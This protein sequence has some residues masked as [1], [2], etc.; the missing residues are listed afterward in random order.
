MKF[1]KEDEKCYHFSDGGKVVKVAKSGMSD[2]FRK[3]YFAGGLVEEAKKIG[4]KIKG[5]SEQS[6]LGES[7]AYEQVEGINQQQLNQRMDDTLGEIGT[8]ANKIRKP[9]GYANGG[10]VIEDPEL[11]DLAN[12]HGLNPGAKGGLKNAWALENNYGKSNATSVQGARGPMQVM[13]AV[14]DALKRQGHLSPQADINNPSDNKL[15]AVKLMAEA[16]NGKLK[17]VN[18]PQ[19]FAAYYHGGPK[20]IDNY[21]K[22][23]P[24]RKDALGTKTVDYAA[25]AAQFQPQQYKS[26]AQNDVPF[27]QRPEQNFQNSTQF[28]PNQ[29]AIFAD[30]QYPTPQN[31]EDFG[32]LLPVAARERGSDAYAAGQAQYAQQHFGARQGISADTEQAM[33]DS[34]FGVPGQKIGPDYN[35]EQQAPYALAAQENQN[36]I[37]QAQN[38]GGSGVIPAS[39]QAQDFSPLGF[40]GNPFQE[41]YDAKSQALQT[42]AGAQEMQRQAEVDYSGRMAKQQQDMINRQNQLLDESNKQIDAFAKDYMANKVDPNKLF[43]NQST[44]RMF[45]GA[46]GLMLSGIGSALTGQPSQ[47]LM[48]I[49]RAIDRD[50]EAQKLEL[51]KGKT[52]LDLQLQK[53]G[54]ER[55]AIQATRIMLGAQALA[56]MEKAK[57]M[58][59]KP[60]IQAALQMNQANLKLALVQQMAEMKNRMLN[61]RAS[62]GY[63]G[64]LTFGTPEYAM[65]LNNNPDLKASQYV[66]FKAPGQPAKVYFANTPQEAQ[67]FRNLDVAY[68]N[69]KHEVEPLLDPNFV[70]RLKVSEAASLAKQAIDVAKLQFTTFEAAGVGSTRIS[71]LERELSD[72]IIA[73]PTSW[74]PKNLFNTQKR[75]AKFLE[76]IKGARDQRARA[77]FPNYEIDKSPSDYGFKEA[78]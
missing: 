4:K 64:A 67:N 39:G 43:R 5:L 8:T 62:T 24:N 57:A 41:V 1:L 51:G 59:R 45:T 49:D 42:Q 26:S 33:I 46:I 2:N 14:F 69:I 78:K 36:M 48:V 44:G 34:R 28:D 22:I 66:D 25:N 56:E 9:Q 23:N 47:A 15:A 29:P 20:A 19:M 54:N 70:R 60:E 76:Q 3:K 50:I 65:A 38:Q 16:Q 52:I 71:E 37:R 55:D 63:G 53:Y 40:Q 72:D 61:F 6:E 74:S 77:F 18:D 30:T 17:G 13:P 58:A 75:L 35:E 68:R 12:R 73:D 27:Y 7:E 10:I 21:G 11:E 32:N 31:N